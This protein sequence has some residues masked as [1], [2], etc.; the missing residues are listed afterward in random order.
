MPF[1]ASHGWGTNSAQCALDVL[2]SGQNHPRNQFCHSL[3]ECAS[4]SL[5]PGL[6]RNAVRVFPLLTASLRLLYK[7]KA[8]LLRE[9]A[10]GQGKTRL[11]GRALIINFDG[12]CSHRGS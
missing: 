4:Y 12:A 7:R 5:E 9:K 3:P 1:P 2:V 8:I 6:G 11:W 10:S